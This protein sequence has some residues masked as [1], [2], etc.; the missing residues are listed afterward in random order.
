MTK[1]VL[2][3]GGNIEPRRAFMEKAF[4]ALEEKLGS[5]D[6]TSAIYETAAWGGKSEGAYLNQVL[7]FETSMAPEVVLS[8][9][10]LIEDELG[11][12]RTE[13]WGNRT[14]DIDILYYGD[15]V[16]QSPR[17]QIPHP[18]IQE[19]QFV[20]KPICEIIP[21]FIHPVLGLSQKELLLSCVD[22]SEVK[23]FEFFDLN[24]KKQKSG[25]EKGSA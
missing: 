23:V 19:R 18:W 11:R 16:Y 4:L 15:L 14:M 10:R 8:I 5:C 25:T 17:L 21:D 13:T 7:I 2:I 6:Q 3:I 20:L 22:Q 1:V 12:Q 9:T 24:S